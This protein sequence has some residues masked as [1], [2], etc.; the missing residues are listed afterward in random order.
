[1]KKINIF[2]VT[3]LLAISSVSFAQSETEEITLTTYYPAPYGDYDELSADSMAVSRMSVGTTY[4]APADNNFIVEGNVGIGTAS[5]E[6]G[7]H[8]VNRTLML[9]GDY[10]GSGRVVFR[11][12][13]TTAYSDKHQ[14]EI[15]PTG[16]GDSG[17]GFVDRNENAYRLFL[18]E[19]G[20]IGI[21]TIAPS[22]K[23]HVDGNVKIGTDAQAY[24]LP[25]S[26]G[27][28]NQILATN[29]NGVVSWRDPAGGLTTDLQQN[30]GLRSEAL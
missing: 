17:L 11:N 21:G 29:A 7:I 18:S 10:A 23:L 26:R 6:T 5:P 14:W 15:Y 30:G 16:T 24:T 9:D 20:N 13:D 12:T 27:T 1:M 28:N 8:A 25:A 2:L 3:A 22:A 19:T 4:T